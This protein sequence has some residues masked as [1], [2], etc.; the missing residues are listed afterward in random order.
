MKGRNLEGE[1]MGLLIAKQLIFLKPVRLLIKWSHMA[2]IA[3]SV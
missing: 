1:M 2:L 3:W